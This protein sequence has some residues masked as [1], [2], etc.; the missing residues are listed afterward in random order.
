MDSHIDSL[1][2]AVVRKCSKVAACPEV[3][4]IAC[5]QQTSEISVRTY[6]RDKQAKSA[7]L[8]IQ[9]GCTDFAIF[10]NSLI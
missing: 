10:V 9:N 1:I 2:L 6:G 4:P 7:H 3:S 8:R 5:C